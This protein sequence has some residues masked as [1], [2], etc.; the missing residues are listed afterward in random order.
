[1]I[2][3]GK[4]RYPKLCGFDWIE[5]C[6]CV[7]CERVLRNLNCNLTSPFPRVITPFPLLFVL[8]MEALSQLLDKAVKGQY[9][10]GFSVA[11]SISAPLKV[12]HLLFAGD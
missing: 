12:S 10:E 9:L 5:F 3:V 11:S 8:V 2:E 1:M 4:I 6:E 7:M